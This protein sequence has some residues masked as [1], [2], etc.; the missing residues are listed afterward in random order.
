MVGGDARGRM[1]AAFGDTQFT[2]A[3]IVGNVVLKGFHHVR[4][5]KVHFL[6]GFTVE[7]VVHELG[8]VLDNRGG[9]TFLTAL[10]GG[11]RADQMAYRNG[12][13]PHQCRNRSNCGSIYRNAKLSEPAPTW[14]AANGPSEDFAESFRLSVLSPGSLGPIRTAF[15]DRLANSLTTST[16]E[17]SGSPYTRLDRHGEGLL[18]SGRGGGSSSGDLLR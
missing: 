10:H 15:F 9:T 14:Y 16:A 7:D 3:G 17:F 4:G 12:F 6:P 5:S 8:H 11:G 18:S 1:R 2:K 13:N